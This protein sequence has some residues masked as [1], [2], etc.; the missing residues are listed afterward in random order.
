MALCT[1]EKEGRASRWLAG[2]DKGDQR[3]C[4]CWLDSRC[5]VGC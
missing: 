4:P 5:S 3:V 1:S 2:P